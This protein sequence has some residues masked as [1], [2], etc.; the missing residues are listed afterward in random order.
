MKAAMETWKALSQAR[1]PLGD[2]CSREDITHEAEWVSEALTEL[3]NQ[4]A[5]PTQVT[6]F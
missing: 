4:H 2:A 5:K 3:L 6:S 1:A